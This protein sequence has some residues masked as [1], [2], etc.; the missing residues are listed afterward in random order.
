MLIDKQGYE[1]IQKRLILN[2]YIKK[3]YLSAFCF[4]VFS[5]CN[6][7]GIAKKSWYDTLESL[8]FDGNTNKLITRQLYLFD[9]SIKVL[10]ILRGEKEK[11]MKEKLKEWLNNLLN[12]EKVTVDD[13]G[14]KTISDTVLTEEIDG[15][16]IFDDLR[17]EQQQEKKELKIEDISGLVE[18]V[19]EIRRLVE[20]VKWLKSL[21]EM[22]NTVNSDTDTLT[23][24]W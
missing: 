3:E 23:E 19:A 15:L 14:Q 17:D 18:Q 24:I 9:D 12:S 1:E 2:E 4:I 22:E 21:I 5:Q 13:A 20:E 16:D 11:Y 8:E 10:L 6:H 7:I